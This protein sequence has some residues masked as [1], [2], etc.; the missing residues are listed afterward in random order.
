MAFDKIGKKK[1]KQTGFNQCQ[2]T[3][4]LNYE[5]I[6]LETWNLLRRRPQQY[7]L[8]HN[9]TKLIKQSNR[10]TQRHTTCERVMIE[11]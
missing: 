4:M 5:Y 10:R 8:K 7:L 11:C 2:R 1:T 6:D 9:K 3:L